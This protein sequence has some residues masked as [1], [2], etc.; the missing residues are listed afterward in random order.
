[1]ARL[2]GRSCELDA[3]DPGDLRNLVTNRI[4]RHMSD[5]RLAELEAE[6]R[7]EKADLERIIRGLERR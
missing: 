7:A 5:E 4:A 6:E 3:F 2:I 1:M